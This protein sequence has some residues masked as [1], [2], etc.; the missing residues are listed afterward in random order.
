MTTLVS[1][2]KKIESENKTN[3][4]TFYSHSK[5]ERNI[6]ESDING[7][8]KSVYTTIISNVQ[9]LLGKVSG[10]I[11]DSGIDHNII[12]SKY[13]RL[14]ESS[15]LRL[16]KES[17]HPRKGLINI[18]NIADNEYFKW[19]LVRYLNP[20]DHQRRKIKKDDKGFGKKLDFNNIKCPVKVLVFLALKIKKNIQSMY[21]KNV[22]KENMLTYY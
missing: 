9:K 11:I 13:N 8:F 4:D 5:A 19:C 16:P 10:W 14:A 18:Q 12:I 20:T 15:Y 1:V 3:Y 2:F 17:D 22:V 7:M 6:N 21:Q